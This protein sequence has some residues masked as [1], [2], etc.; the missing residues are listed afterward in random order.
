MVLRFFG[1]LGSLGIP[2]PRGILGLRGNFGSISSP[3][4][5]FPGS[6]VPSFQPVKTAA[7]TRR[8]C[9]S[10]FIWFSKGTREPGNQMDRVG[11][12][13]L[14]KINLARFA[15]S[16]VATVIIVLLEPK[17]QRTQSGGAAAQLVLW[18]LGRV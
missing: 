12:I 1:I 13:W 10:L 3:F 18:F 7:H 15:R 5:W 2:G 17:N 16:V 9:G 6:L 8:S 11:T 4:I 14:V